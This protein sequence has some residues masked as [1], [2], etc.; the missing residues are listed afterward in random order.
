ME[1]VP[2]VESV[3]VVLVISSEDAVVKD[4]GIEVDTVVSSSVQVVL[5]ATDCMV[6]TDKTFVMNL[7]TGRVAVLLADIEDSIFEAS[8][9]EADVVV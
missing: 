4:D 1:N 5:V 9:V 6:L 7:P 2:V 8:L 3:H